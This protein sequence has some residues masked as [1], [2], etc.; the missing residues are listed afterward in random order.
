[1]A[2]FLPLKTPKAVTVVLNFSP[3]FRGGGHKA[4]FLARNITSLRNQ[5]GVFLCCWQNIV[6]LFWPNWKSNRAGCSCPIPM[7]CRDRSGSSCR[8]SAGDLEAAG[9]AHSHSLCTG[10]CNLP[11]CAGSSSSSV[12]AERAPEQRFTAPVQ[13]HPD[14]WVMAGGSSRTNEIFPCVLKVRATSWAQR[15]VLPSCWSRLV[16]PKSC[17]QF[18]L[19]PSAWKLKWRHH[20]NTQCRLSLFI[21]PLLPHHVETQTIAKEVQH[22]EKQAADTMGV[23]DTEPENTSWAC[24]A[25]QALCWLGRETG[26]LCWWTWCENRAGRN[27]EE[28]SECW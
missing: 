1:M 10:Q 15:S 28:R 9:R 20:S 16:C 21:S 7:T 5:W 14:P 23:W 22:P 18:L 12:S 17:V 8:F 13:Q 19:A 24:W 6:E 27:H 26:K 3:A 2:F 25:Q 4:A 11:G